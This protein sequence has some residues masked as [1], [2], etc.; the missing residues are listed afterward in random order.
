M[1]APDFDVRAF[2]R[3]MRT[4]PHW[5]PITATWDRE[6]PSPSQW[7]TS[8]GEHMVDWFESQM[9]LGGGA[10]SRTAPN[11]SARRTYNRL[12]SVGGLLWIGEAMGAPRDLVQ[13]AADE[14]ARE[15]DNRRRCGIIRRHIPWEMVASLAAE[16]EARIA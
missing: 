12:L 1:S 9:T 7:W 3:I 6:H 10:Y 8:Q 5:P 15:R 11:R 16:R 14:S 13:L 2:A 4:L